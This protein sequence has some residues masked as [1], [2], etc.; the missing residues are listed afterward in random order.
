MINES[1]HPLL[2][3][4]KRTLHEAELVDA[5]PQ[6]AYNLLTAGTGEGTIRVCNEHSKIA[7]ILISSDLQ[8]MVYFNTVNEISQ[9]NASVPMILLSNFVTLN[10]IRVATGIGC[11]EILQRGLPGNFRRNF[12]QIFK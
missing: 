6:K 9:N 7:V 2:F 8:G 11:S 3:A 1:E 10:S 5:F 4:L 12:T